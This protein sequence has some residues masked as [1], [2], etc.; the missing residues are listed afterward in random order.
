[1]HGTNFR[2]VVEQNSH[3]RCLESGTNFRYPVETRRHFRCL[4]SGVNFRYVVGTRGRFRCLE[5]ST[6]LVV[7]LKIA[8]TFVCVQVVP[9]QCNCVERV[10]F[11]S[12]L[13]A[14]NLGSEWVVLADLVWQA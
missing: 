1:M 11:N 5:S 9:M 14:L 4:E 2:Y 12:L 10:C 8:D 7:C 6:I 3:F 13:L